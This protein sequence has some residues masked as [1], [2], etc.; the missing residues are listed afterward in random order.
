LVAG[1]TVGRAL[2]A[3]GCVLHENIALI[4]LRAEVLVA[5]GGAAVGT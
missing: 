1:V 4:A 2:F 3:Q 5:T